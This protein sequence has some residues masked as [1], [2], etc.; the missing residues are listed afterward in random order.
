[1]RIKDPT[2]LAQ[3]GM[4]FKKGGYTPAEIAKKYD[5][6][7]YKKILAD[8]NTDDLQRET[9]E[10]MIANNNLK[11]AKLAIYQ[12][13]MKGFPQGMPQVGMPY[14]EEMEIDPAQ[15]V[16]ENPGQGDDE[17]A[18]AD[19][20]SRFGGPLPKAQWGKNTQSKMLP[21]FSEY[22]P[23]AGASDAYAG[24][25]T[26]EGT[27]GI[28]GVEG[29]EGKGLT[30]KYQDWEMTKKK[31][32]G[33]SGIAKAEGILGGL[34]GAQAF[35]NAREMLNLNQQMKDGSVYDNAVN[36]V[37]ANEIGRQGS[38]VEFG[39]AAGTQN[40]YKTGS[41]VQQPGMNYAIEGMVKYGGD[42]D[43]FA[44]GGYLPRAQKGFESD[45]LT[46]PS[47][48]FVDY[49][50]GGDE[51]YAHVIHK[52]KKYYRD[53]TDIIST[54]TDKAV[55]DPFLKREILAEIARVNPNKWDMAELNKWDMA[56][57]KEPYGIPKGQYEY[58]KGLYVPALP[59]MEKKDYDFFKKY[60]EP[61]KL[62]ATALNSNNPEIMRK[63][64]DELNKK[65]KMQDLA[66][67]LRERAAKVKSTTAKSAT[68]TSNKVVPG[69]YT[70]PFSTAQEDLGEFAS[71]SP[72]Y[73]SAYKAFEKAFNSGNAEEMKNTANF[74]KTVETPWYS[75]SWL[76]YTH[77]DK[78]Q[79]L[80]GILEE[81]SRGEQ[82]IPSSDSLI[83]KAKQHS[84]DVAGRVK[85]TSS[86]LQMIAQ[87]SPDSLEGAKAANLLKQF[88]DYNPYYK[89]RKNTEKKQDK[90]KSKA[91]GPSTASDEMWYTPE[92]E[93][94]INKVYDFLQNNFKDVVSGKKKLEFLG[95]PAEPVDQSTIARDI[96]KTADTSTTVTPA[97][98]AITT[99]DAEML[100]Q[101]EALLK[102][103]NQKPA[104]KK[105]PNV[106]ETDEDFKEGG[107]I[108]K[109]RV[110]IHSLGEYRMGGTLPKAQDGVT[111]EAKGKG[112]WQHS[113]KSGN[114]RLKYSDGT[115]GPVQKETPLLVTP[116]KGADAPS[117]YTEE[118]W[119]EF[120]KETGFTPQSADP[121]EQNKEFQYHLAKHKD[122]A[123]KVEA[124]HKQYG[125][126]KGGK[127]DALLGRRWDALVDQRAPKK[128]VSETSSVKED[129][130]KQTYIDPGVYA[131][132]LK[133]PRVP[134]VPARFTVQ[135]TLKGAN[136]MADYLG[137]QRS[138]V[139]SAKPAFT[140]PNVQYLSPLGQYQKIGEQF[141]IAAQNLAQFGDP[142]QYN[143]RLGQLQ[144]Q[145]LAA[146]ADT[147]AR[148]E[149]ENVR[150]GNAQAAQNAAMFNAFNQGEA[151]RR[152]K[153]YESNIT[154]DDVFR[155]ERRFAR[156]AGVNQLAN[157][158]TNRANI[159]NV[160]QLY[161]QF[162]V[163]PTGMMYFKNPR[164]IKP[165][166][167]KQMTV[168]D[169]FN[170]ILEKN[171][172]LRNEKGM[173]IAYDMAK[174]M[175]GTK[176]K[177]DETDEWLKASKGIIPSY[178]VNPYGYNN[179]QGT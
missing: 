55:T 103:A 20:M 53:N 143:A 19:N 133:Q 86:Y 54:D 3:F 105:Y 96:G 148:T 102:G 21:K 75:A 161:P 170:Q 93:A 4:P 156:N 59:G 127:F 119:Q 40:P 138:P 121:T 43:Y 47:G 165:D 26:K 76:P 174:T 39:M 61:I 80:A 46:R 136:L 22:S 116:Y 73:A 60:E 164:D 52:G 140:T 83:Q 108:G 57:L 120:A 135:D 179:G 45:T 77:E 87:K 48:S 7:K 15:F 162:A 24:V 69:F 125:S 68:N 112:I 150:I 67:I 110:L 95:A 94:E 175:A 2:I 160:N 16:Q 65:N 89:E 58:T 152:T 35:G 177:T 157:A 51:N 168:N 139:W 111:T 13:S 78:L 106:E 97:A 44:P 142:R 132:N 107:S 144:G 5:T 1:M 32:A 167:S 17:T 42:V 158:F 90:L 131:E 151:A 101:K 99:A 30:G 11:L 36:P 109:R 88:E 66:G 38:N 169:Y 122:W 92:E 118:Q 129:G 34:R 82:N 28:A 145:A 37:E 81:R 63:T 31:K 8:P 23:N 50:W 176:P 149:G 49:Y 155:N 113:T 12:E 100:K 114:W 14:L 91:T 123:P 126:P 27:E 25:D 178:N 166:Y 98:P 104:V 137:V 85:Q 172:N 141:N 72:H 146:V 62:Y 84:K 154:A 29:I 18:E 153:D 173:T 171:E 41:L 134:N 6:S 33:I 64:A 124:L 115:Y 70:G 79:D 159:Y 56:E 74:L 147:A 71:A 128:G 130:K 163:D 117:K 9:A 10:L